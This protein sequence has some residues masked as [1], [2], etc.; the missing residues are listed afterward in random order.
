MSGASDNNIMGFIPK[1]EYVK[2]T[3]LTLLGAAGAGLLLSLFALL[4]FPLPLQN[5][6]MLANIAGLL[7][8]I[9]G[10]FVFKNEFSALDQSHLLYIV[11]II[12]VFLVASIILAPALAIVWFLATGVILLLAVAQ[13]VMMYTGY[14][15]WKRGRTITKENVQSEIQLALKRS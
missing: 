4:G 1:G 6:I 14:N 2:I 8:A 7:L 3:Y 10:Y 5:L 13:L 11:V 9:L 12:G 15:S